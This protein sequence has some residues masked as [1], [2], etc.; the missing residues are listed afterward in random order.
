MQ[1]ACPFCAGAIQS[2][3]YAETLHCRAIYNR[4]P[5]VKG[6][7]LVVPKR[8]VTRLEALSSVELTDLFG[9]ARHVAALLLVAFD[10]DGYDLSLQQGASAGQTVAH[11]HAHIV[12]R[13][14]N[15]LPHGDWHTQL[16]DSA[17]RPRLSSTEMAHHVARLRALFARSAA[18][19]PPPV[20]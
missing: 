18:P 8:H 16:L 2:S 9:L 3:T 12:P 13:R 10:C 19:I 11:L 14:P 7:S 1:A 15:D 4:A 17:S 5:L 20:P 6:H